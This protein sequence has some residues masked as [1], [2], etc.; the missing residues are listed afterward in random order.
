M[1][2]IWIAVL[3]LAAVACGS[4]KADSNNTQEEKQV[5]KACTYN[6]S[7]NDASV[8]WEA[9]KL[10]NKIGVGGQ[11]DSLS[12]SLNENDASVKDLLTNAS[13]EIFTQSVNSKDEVR[14]GKLRNIFFGGLEA[15]VITGEI[16]SVEGNNDAGKAKARL[17]MNNVENSVEFNYTTSDKEIKLTASI[18]MLA[19]AADAP[20][21]ALNEACEEKHTGPDG[22]NKLW[23][24]V[25]VNFFAPI[26][27]T[28]E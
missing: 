12:L 24:D 23:P 6:L 9:Y 26:T 25:K 4:P 13:I 11:F 20:F 7:A 8:Y 1:K 18:D 14:D 5:E 3:A 22:V 21:K 27:K 28:C 2:N 17:M 15:D 16:I 19:F 10:T